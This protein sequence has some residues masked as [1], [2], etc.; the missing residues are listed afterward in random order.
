MYGGHH[1]APDLRGGVAVEVHLLGHVV[2][3]PDG[4]RVI[5]RGAAE[6]A[7]PVVRRGAGLAGHGHGPEVGLRA[8]AAAG[9]AVEHVEHVIGRVGLHR[10]VRFDV[11]LQNHAAGGVRHLGIDVALG[12]DAAVDEGAE[13]LR[14]LA[15]GGAVG[16]LAQGEG[17]IVPVLLDERGDAKVVLQE[18]IGGVHPQLVQHLRG[19][20]VQRAHDRPADGDDA[21]IIVA[22]V[23]RVPVGVAGERYLARRRVVHQRVLGDEPGLDGGGVDAQGL[24]RGAGRALRL[25]GPVGDEVG[26]L[27]AHAAGQ[28]HDGARVGVHD[29]DGALQLLLS[30]AVGLG[31]GV[32]VLIDG[33]HVGLDVRVVAGVD[34][35][36]AGIE[37]LLRR[38]GADALLRHQV[39][40]HVLD[41]R[42]HVPGVDLLLPGLVG[43]AGEHQL[44]VDGGAVFV[45][46]DIA[47]LVH[48]AQDGLLPGLVVGLAVEGAVIGGQVDDADDGGALRQ[49]QLAGFL[50]EVRL[51]RGV[52]AVA[53]L[54]EIDGVQVPG[55]DLVLVVLLLELQRLEY[56]DQLALDG[57]VVVA[58]EVLDEL[59]GYR[60]AAEDVVRGG[61]HGGDGGQRAEPVHALVLI[62]AAVLDGDEGLHQIVGDVLQVHPDAVLPAGEGGQLLPFAVVV[63]VVDDARLGEG[64][65]REGDVQVVLQRRL[66]IEGKYAGEE[67]PRGEEDEHCRRQYLHSQADRAKNAPGN[68]AGGLLHAVELVVIHS[69]SHLRALAFARPRPLQAIVEY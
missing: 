32:Q 35:V 69:C 54:A 8:G 33:V 22:R 38:V 26:R 49:G 4:G 61:E 43:R 68:A 27:F 6:P 55:D 53:A 58:G 23:A 57:D 30:R 59:L 46:V 21:V 9:R 41:D 10:H 51:G 56:L 20:S 12:E 2:A 18:V 5:G 1:A 3:G 24:E 34:A 37:E 42:L 40:L 64:V 16:Q 63:L 11:V 47:L 67:Q 31:Q 19:H 65:V 25:R 29:D 52:D 66:D 36:A 15:H 50:A 7:V 39:G 48:L 13:G 17:G 60:G 14:H 44:F 45:I 28:G 62:E